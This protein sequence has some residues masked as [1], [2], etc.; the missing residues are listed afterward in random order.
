MEFT[1]DIFK[2]NPPTSKT[3]NLIGT[4]LPNNIDYFY[5][6][7]QKELLDQYQ[8]A[9]I[10]LSETETTDWTHYFQMNNN[11]TDEIFKLI[12]KGYLYETALYYYNVIIDLSWSLCYSSL[13]FACTQN[14]KRVSTSVMSPIDK[15]YDL[16][17]SVEKN[18]MGPTAPENPFSYLKK[19]NY[20]YSNVIDYIIDFWEK[21][22]DSDVR[23]KYNYCKHRGKPLYTELS[24]YDNTRFFGFYVQNKDGDTTQ[25]VSDISD[26]QYKMSLND[27]IEEL[28]RFDDEMLY[29]Y[30]KG[31]FPQIEKLINLSPMV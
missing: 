17:R 4:V 5:R 10:F 27:S 9:R 26:V 11:D 3:Y 23:K 28:R 16:L 14:G 8:G 1:T 30:I 13:E 25:L 19:L 22:M 12:L 18:V 31:L 2:L 20:E 21:F 24:A 15:A 29:P 7:K 6:A